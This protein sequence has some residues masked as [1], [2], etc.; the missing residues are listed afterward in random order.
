MSEPKLAIPKDKEGYQFPYTPYDN[1]LNLMQQI[2]DTIENKKIGIFESPTGTGKSLSL[3]CASMAWLKANDSRYQE[4]LN[5]PIEVIIDSKAGPAWLQKQ[6][7][8]RKL[9]QKI[10]EIEQEK[11]LLNKIKQKEALEIKM[12]K[13]GNK[14]IKNQVNIQNNTTHNNNGLQLIDFSDDDLLLD[15]NLDNQNNNY[16]S[17]VKELLS[18]L[19]DIENNQILNEFNKNLSHIEEPDLIKIYYASRTH[20]QLSQFITEYEK[21][22]Y[23]KIYDDKNEE[24]KY[25]TITLGGRNNL[26]NNTTILKSSFGNNEVLNERCLEL[27]KPEVKSEK[28]CPYYL[29]SNRAYLNEFKHNVLKQIKDIE[30][31]VKLGNGLGTCSYYGVRKS[32]AKARLVCVPYNLLLNQQSRESSGIKLENNIVIIDEAHNLIEALQSNYS[33]KLTFQQINITQEQVNNYLIKYINRLSGVN[34]MYLKQ[35]LKILKALKEYLEQCGSDNRIL[36]CSEFLIQIQLDQIN[37]LEIINYLKI[38]KLNHKLHG[39]INKNHDNSDNNNILN[40]NSNNNNPNLKVYIYS[41]ASFLNCLTLSDENGKLIIETNNNIKS[42][43]YLLLNSINSFQQIIEQSRS[44][45]LI[46]GTLAPI[47]EYINQ[48]IEPKDYNNIIQFSC[49]HVIDKK[50][51]L[52][53]TLNQGININSN[54]NKS[55]FK[56]LKFVNNT[57]NNLELI[58][59]TIQLLFQMIKKIPMG[60]IVFFTSYEYLN[61]FI[62]VLKQSNMYQRINK[63]KKVFYETNII[64][65]SSSSSSSFNNTNTFLLYQNWID[66]CKTK[67]E[68]DNNLNNNSSNNN[69]D[70]ILG[71]IL[72]SVIGGK[73]SEGINFSDDLGRGVIVIGLPYPNLKSLD[74]TLKMDYLDFKNNTI[75]NKTTSK[76]YYQNLCMRSVNQS[77]G[78]VIRHIQDYA[79]ILLIDERYQSNNVIINKL[80]NWIQPSLVHCNNINQI[81]KKLIDF[82][83]QFE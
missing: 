64:T 40:N 69:E 15:D 33:T 76:D 52:C 4:A 45:I 75:N 74:L 78:R 22:S 79:V 58:E 20:S 60:T 35:L 28:K 17:K 39:F 9:K 34:L 37:L 57:K 59:D 55:E 12:A 51:L 24:L 43:R 68:N 1:Q 3:I 66:Y 6:K 41:I 50:N 80:P 65:P 11:E 54:N 44:T 63:V 70:G 82:F 7:I 16:D 23:S 31:L 26:C 10:I 42:I 14:K 30:D 49:N 38:S 53:L 83:K 77:I 61:N 19:E 36:K 48:L 73:L 2:F 25:S 32:I 47:N 67:K 72:F 18:E 29:P 8:Q 62:N 21:T 13:K 46:G 5:K 27:Q 81:E 56:S 71:G